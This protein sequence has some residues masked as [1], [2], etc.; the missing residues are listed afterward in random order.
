MLIFLLSLNDSN[1]NVLLIG[2]C[3]SYYSRYD[4]FIGDKQTLHDCQ[5]VLRVTMKDMLGI[6]GKL[7]ERKHVDKKQ[8]TLFR[9]YCEGILILKHFQRPGA[10][11]GMTVN[12]F[13]TV[14]LQLVE[15]YMLSVK[16]FACPDSQNRPTF[17]M[18]LILTV[19]FIA[20][21]TSE[22]FNKRLHHGRVC[23][24]VREHKTATMQIATFAL[25]KEEASVSSPTG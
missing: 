5:R 8:K 7:L 2:V 21:Q 1:S 25:T 22:W 23:V 4:W 13:P 16:N 10:V 20:H 24:G 6:Y 11:Q 14:F 17:F 12:T 3:V 15:Y 19:S 9:Y 18:S